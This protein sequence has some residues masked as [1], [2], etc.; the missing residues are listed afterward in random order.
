MREPSRTGAR[1]DKVIRGND[2]HIYN[3]NAYIKEIRMYYST[4]KSDQLAT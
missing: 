3:I 1:R 4:N 2:E